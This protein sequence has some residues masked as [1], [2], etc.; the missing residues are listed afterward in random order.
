MK[1]PFN[2]WYARGWRRAVDENGK[3]TMV[4]EGEYYTLGADKT[5]LRRKKTEAALLFAIHA[6]VYLASAVVVSDGAMW[7]WVGLFQILTLLPAIYLAMGTVRFCLGG[8]MLTYRDWHAGPVRL[9]RASAF[10]TALGAAT[11]AAEIVYMVLFDCVLW[12]ETL[13]AAEILVYTLAAMGIGRFCRRN[14][15]R[16]IDPTKEEN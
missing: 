13:F 16:I 7:R 6:L 9:R 2:K 5:A 8:E 14:H 3:T 15:F 1:D 10:S 11:L 12:R 4:Y